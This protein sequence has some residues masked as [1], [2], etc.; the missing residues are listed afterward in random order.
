MQPGHINYAVRLN[1][2]L[3]RFETRRT[4]TSA[5]VPKS[6]QLKWS[7][8]DTDGEVGPRVT[9][10]AVAASAPPAVPEIIEPDLE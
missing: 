5:E 9:Q 2:A 3:A 1:Q 10:E 8:E 6:R 7:P 4:G